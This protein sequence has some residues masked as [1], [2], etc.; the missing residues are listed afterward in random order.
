MFRNWTELI[1]PKGVKIDEETFNDFYGKFEIKPLERGFGT[2]LGNSLR[3][4]LL[5]SLQGAAITSVKIDKVL[6][7]YSTVKNVREDVTEIILNLKEIHLKLID[8]EDATL[9]LHVK[10]HKGEKE[11]TAKDIEVVSGVEI[12][13]PDVHIATLYDDAELKM[14]MSVK[15]GKGYIPSEKVRETL[16]DVTA[17]P[18]D[19]AFSPI[20]K[21]N[22]LASDTRVGQNTDYDR[23]TL[24]IWTNGGVKPD[25]ALAYA[26]KILK[27]QL[28]VFVNFEDEGGTEV[29]SFEEAKSKRPAKQIEYLNKRVE[30][31]EL[32]VRSANCLQN[33][34]I[35]YMGELVQKTESE[36]LKT[37][38]F[39][40]KSLNEIREILEE[41]NLN[42]G[43]KLPDWKAPKEE[44]E[45]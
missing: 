32:S 18:L 11:I 28:T 45:E 38:N 21:V 36:M 25:D 22:F 26:A 41:M 20:K 29:P 15:M 34:N 2:T 24:E 42:L 5:S 35:K 9:T 27:E 1:R 8:K 4:V 39:G 12:L 37:K 17:I 7:E 23:L 13:N 33:A 44:N 14:E 3:R 6:H 30:E 40:R 31:L 19:S 16:D 43:M 10:S